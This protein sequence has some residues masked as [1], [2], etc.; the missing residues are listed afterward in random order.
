MKYIV[1]YLCTTAVFLGIYYILFA[2]AAVASYLTDGTSN[3]FILIALAAVS[4]LMGPLCLHSK[5]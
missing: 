5:R 4:G 1:S 3:Y 2:L